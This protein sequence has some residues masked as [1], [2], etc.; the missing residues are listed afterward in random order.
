[1]CCH[2]GKLS[3]NSLPKFNFHIIFVIILTDTFTNITLFSKFPL[4][5]IWQSFQTIVWRKKSKAEKIFL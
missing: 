3:K 2:D 1:M 4:V 5:S